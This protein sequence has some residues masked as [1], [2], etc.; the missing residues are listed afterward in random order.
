MRQ[1]HKGRR[2]AL[3]T[4]LGALVLPAHAWGQA[5]PTVVDPNLAVRTVATGLSQPTGLA[6]IG[7]NDMLVNEKATGRVMRVRNGVVEGPVLDLAVNSAS[8]RGLLGIALHRNFMV[9]GFVYLF[10]SETP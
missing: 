8:E 1:L 5:T 10:W 2:L 9:N 7:T 6:F 4:V 3:L